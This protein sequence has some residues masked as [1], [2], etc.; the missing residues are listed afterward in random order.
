[1]TTQ[2][3]RIASDVINTVV[4]NG[5]VLS[6]DIDSGLFS[7][8]SLENEILFECR[9]RGLGHQQTTRVLEIAHVTCEHDDNE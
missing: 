8:S 2:F 7:W 9:E 5:R 3:N 4:D 1:M 6:S